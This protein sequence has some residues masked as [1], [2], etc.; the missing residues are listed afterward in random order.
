VPKPRPI[1]TLG[2]AQARLTQSISQLRL[3][4][5]QSEQNLETTIRDLAALEEQER[6]LR[7]EVERVEGKR[8]WTEEFRV[9]VEMLGQFLEEKASQPQKTNFWNRR[10]MSSSRNSRQ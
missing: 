5:T 8:E 4:K 9:W 6:D 1:P 10:L 2:P 3:T 7:I